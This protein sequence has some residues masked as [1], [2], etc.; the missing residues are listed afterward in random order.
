VQVAESADAGTPATSSVAAPAVN[1]DGAIA[2]APV[3]VTEPASNIPVLRYDP[4]VVT[5][6]RLSGVDTVALAGTIH[7]SLLAS[8][9]HVGEG[10]IPAAQRRSLAWSL[11]D[12]FEHR[13][14]MSRDLDDGDTFHILVERLQQPNGKIIINRI[15]GARLSLG[16]QVVEA[17][18]Y[19]SRNSSSE[20]FD[21]KG[22]SLTASFLR[23]PVNF[24]RISSVF[25]LREHPIFGTWRNHTGTDYA[26]PMGTPVRAIGDGV[27]VNAGWMGGYGRVID[28]RHANG[29]VSRY[30]H[31]S[32]FASGLHA[33]EHVKMGE[34]IGFVGMTGWATGPH[35]HFEIRVNG[36]ARDPKVAL[37]DRTGDPLTGSDSRLFDETRRHMLAVM[38]RTPTGSVAE[39]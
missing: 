8:L 15:L 3:I 23:T 11:A 30:G 33:G 9:Q 34:T 35:L 6:R 21:G 24:R 39:N 13:I 20:W 36:V 38:Q 18:H 22:K 5:A 19:K 14:D 32:R 25:G 37:K 17:F 12:I 4:V 10:E 27:V 16:D 29:Y 7:A 28:I 1:L 26:A 31:L 2:V